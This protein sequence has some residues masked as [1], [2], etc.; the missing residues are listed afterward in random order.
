MSARGSSDRSFG[1]VFA[2]VCALLGS[3]RLVQGRPSAW[4]WFVPALGFGLAALL[5]PAWLA[6]LNRLWTR[7]GLLLGRV[8]QPIVLGLLFFVVV[9]PIGL[10]MRLSGNDPL[11]LKWRHDET[12]YW[13]RR[14]PPGPAPDS[15]RRQF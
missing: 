7:F 13:L 1:L 5:V 15:M 11:R 10:V 12:S 9:T 6:P 14:E 8:T 3:L 2:G 4:L